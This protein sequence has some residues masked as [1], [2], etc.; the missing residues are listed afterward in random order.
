MVFKPSILGEGVCHN[1]GFCMNNW[2]WGSA[3]V[4][5]DTG[6]FLGCVLVASSKNVQT[7]YAKSLSYIFAQNKWKSTIIT[8]G[9]V[10]VFSHTYFFG[11]HLSCLHEPLFFE[12]QRMHTTGS[13][14]RR[15]L[16]HTCAYTC[17]EQRWHFIGH[18][19]VC[20]AI[21]LQFHFSAILIFVCESHRLCASVSS[22]SS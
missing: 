7:T 9:R 17:E 12:K 22:L 18:C 6:Q 16:V 19:F 4:F 8:R 5:K 14:I 1:F 2:V 3:E 21:R 13:R 20:S 15:L 11:K 10:R